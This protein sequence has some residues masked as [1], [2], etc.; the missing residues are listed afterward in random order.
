VLLGYVLMA[1]RQVAIQLEA[2]VKLLCGKFTQINLP[3]LI[4]YEAQDIHIEI[5]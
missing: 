2:G 3:T 1:I 5:Y 4:T